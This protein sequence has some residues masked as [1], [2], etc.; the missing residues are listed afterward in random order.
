MV[1]QGRLHSCEVIFSCR[2][3]IAADVTLPYPSNQPGEIGIWNEEN[4]RVRTLTIA[5]LWRGDL[6]AFS[7]DAHLIVAKEAPGAVILDATTGAVIARLG[8]PRTLYRITF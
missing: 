6:L 3:E 7:P 5:G 4:Q 2:N 1:L 8:H